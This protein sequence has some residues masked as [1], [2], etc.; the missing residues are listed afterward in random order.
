MSKFTSI[1]IT[2]V[3]RKSAKELDLPIV[4]IF[5][6]ADV[7]HTNMNKWER[8]GK[9]KILPNRRTE[10]KILKAI[11]RLSSDKPKP[12]STRAA[13]VVNNI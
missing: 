13:G 3:I 7:D 9:K 5:R 4:A 11:E 12:R 6:E 8:P 2:Q 10:N 1:D